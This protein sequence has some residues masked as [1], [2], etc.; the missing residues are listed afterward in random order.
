MIF[1][2]VISKPMAGNFFSLVVYQGVNYVLP[3]VSFPFLYRMLGETYFGLYAFGW[4]L[5]QNLVMITDFGFNLSATRFISIHRDRPDVINRHLNAAFACRILLGVLCFIAL[6]LLTGFVDKFHRHAVFFLLFFGVVVGNILSPMWFFQGMEKMK[7]AAVFNMTAKFFSIIP[8]FILVRS[9]EDYLWLPV[10][11]SAGYCLAGLVCVYL[12]YVREK[13]DWFLPEWKEMKDVAK[14]SAAYFLSRVSLS[15]FTTVNVLVLGM[16]TTYELVSYYSRAEKFYQAYNG[17]LSPFTGV[18][19]PHIAK[20]RDVPFFKKVFRIIVSVNV[21]L[22]ILVIAGAGWLITF[23]YA[24]SS[25][26]TIK[27]FRILMCSCVLVIPSM[28]LGYPFLAAL[29]HATYVNLTI[30]IVS[31]VHVAGICLLYSAGELSIYTMAIMVVVSEILS[32]SFRVRGTIKY[33]LFK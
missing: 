16:A 30:V 19:F 3:L 14:D 18:L 17:L 23:I 20:T 28:L 22:V 7:Y 12:V 32:F 25:V 1:R 29:G 8:I 11:F 15:M 10:F 4:A 2:G 13:M 9:A 33:K 6:L 31:V 26:E 5:I 21:P 27:V 24:D